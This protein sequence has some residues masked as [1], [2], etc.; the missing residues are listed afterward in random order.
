LHLEWRQLKNRT[1]HDPEVVA[2]KAAAQAAKT[3]LEKRKLMQ[4]YYKIFYAHM[5][6]LA[7]TP[8][9]K[10]Y[11]EQKKNSMIASLDQPHVHPEPTPRPSA[12]P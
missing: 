12:T 11:L 2:A 7:T 8:D 1:V 10:N 4:T 9:V 3:D 6:A 5:E